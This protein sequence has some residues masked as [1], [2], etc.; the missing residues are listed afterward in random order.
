MGT[1]GIVFRLHGMSLDGDLPGLG[2]QHHANLARAQEFILKPFEEMHPRLNGTFYGALY[3]QAVVPFL[4]AQR[5]C[6]VSPT[7][8]QTVQRIGKAMVTRYR[9]GQDASTKNRFKNGALEN[10]HIE[11]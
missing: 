7:L 1:A 5:A 3:M 2:D 11:Y 10:M 6:G 9:I 8:R 4:C